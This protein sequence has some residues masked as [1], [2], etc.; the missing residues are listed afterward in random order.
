M[1]I[2]LKLFTLLL[3]IAVIPM[4]SCSKDDD[5]AACNEATLEAELAPLTTAWLEATF[6]YALNETPENCTAAK[7]ATIAFRD[8]LV[9]NKGCA[10]TNSADFDT[11]IA[12]LDAAI[13]ELSC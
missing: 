6:T 2:L 5:A 7:N 8:S 11:Q 9:K 4:M 13:D 3:F 12:D 10:G 1:K